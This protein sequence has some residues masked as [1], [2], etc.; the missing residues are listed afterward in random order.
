ME[1]GKS[2]APHTTIGVK[3]DLY[4]ALKEW[5]EPRA[6]KVRPFI[7]VLIKKHLE[8]NSGHEW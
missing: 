6:I 1:K 7:E 8:E 4:W 2:K 5:C 3:H